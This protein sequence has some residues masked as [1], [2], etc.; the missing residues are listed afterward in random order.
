MCILYLSLSEIRF[1]GLAAADVRIGLILILF[2]GLL[3]S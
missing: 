1:E 3:D 2:G